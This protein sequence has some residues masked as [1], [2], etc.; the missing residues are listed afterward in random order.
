[1]NSASGMR[2]T[3]SGERPRAVRV[4]G[5]LALVLSCLFAAVQGASAESGSAS[6][7]AATAVVISGHG[8]GHGIGLSQWGAEERAAAGQTYNEILSFYYPGTELRTIP[9]TNIRV[10][11]TEQPRLQIGSRTPFTI[12]DA[13]HRVL[14]LAGGSYALTADGVLGRRQ[15]QLPLVVRPGTA[16]LQLGG[17]HYHGTLTIALSEGKL[18]AVNTLA[19]EDY[20]VDVVSSE[21]PG[22]WPSAALRAQAVASRSFAFTSMGAHARFDVYPDDRSQNYHGMLKEFPSAAAAVAATRQQ[23]LFYAGAPVRAFFSASNGGLT[24]GVE[25][26]WQ[27]P[28]LPY[29]VSRPD[30]FDAESP[31]LNWGPITLN[32]GQLRAA[33]P[34]LPTTILTVTIVHNLAGRAS[35]VTFIGADGSQLQIDGYT[36]Q[37]RLGL[38]S[39]YLSLTPTYPSSSAPTA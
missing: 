8:F 5:V 14:R 1:M 33:F 32:V 39:T 30:T 29:F 3:K 34:G 11:L 24:S 25:D 38:R 7:A 16:P 20:V 2:R 19:L 18:E 17:T 6:S 4:V 21:C 31:D 10:W 35:T 12:Q 27:T 26:V 28:R 22:F 13:G 9:N 15:L 36:F 23:A 37:Q